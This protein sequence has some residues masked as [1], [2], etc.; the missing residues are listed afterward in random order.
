M[1]KYLLS[2]CD[3]SGA[4]SEPW[5]KAGYVVHRID[6]KN[7]GDV[8]LLERRDV[9]YDAILCAPPCTE[10]A[11][12]GARWW[13]RKPGALLVEALSVVDACLR[14][15]QIYR[16]RVWAL[17]NPVGRLVR[18]LGPARFSFQPNEYAGWADDPASEQY[19]KRTCLWGEFAPPE[20][21]ELPAVLGSMM[22]ARYGGR[23]DRTK[24][25]RSMTPTGFARA[26]A[27]ANL[28][29]RKAVA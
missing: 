11:G 21:R 1:R 23:S 2:L 3:F 12:S 5:R 18:Y 26:F 24:E 13:A 9:P 17:E 19:T 7:G 27:A 25:L 6:L 8:R 29:M 4:W 16:P 14:A 10:F 28:E 22:W 20:R 15:V